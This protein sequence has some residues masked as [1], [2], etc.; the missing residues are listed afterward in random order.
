MKALCNKRSIV[1]DTIKHRPG[2]IPSHENFQ[3][4]NTRDRLV[5]P[6]DT[7]CWYIDWMLYTE[8]MDNF[9]IE[10]HP[11]AVDVE[12]LEQNNEFFKQ[13]LPSGAIRTTQRNP[14]LMHFDNHPIKSSRDLHKMDILDPDD[15]RLYRDFEQAFKLYRQQGYFTVAGLGGSVFWTV[16]EE[17]YPLTDL[18]S[19]MALEPDFADELFGRIGEYILGKAKN[20]LS[21]GIDCIYIEDDLGYKNGPFM[22]PDMFRRFLLVWYRKFCDLAHRN[23]LYTYMHSH[24][25]IILLFEDLINIGVDIINPVGPTDNMDLADI[26]KR[27][28]DKV[29]ILGGLSKNIGRMDHETLENHIKEVVEIGSVGGG[30]IPRG[31]SGITAEMDR[32]KFLFYMHTLRKYR[33]KYSSFT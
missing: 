31:E 17:W 19:A 26:K 18:L 23:G 8:Y 21:M 2:I 7:G 14:W 12:V 32:E 10:L 16:A 9:I 33:L 3:D 1:I 15:P 22:S 20:F 4:D 5:Q 25:D 24:G 27:F 29:T 11:H 6:F 30:F 28:G 13:K